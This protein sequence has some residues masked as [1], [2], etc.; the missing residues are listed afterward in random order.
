MATIN[1]TS[2]ND[3]L[4]GTSGNDVIDGGLGN[5][6]L[7]GGG[8]DDTVRGGGGDDAIDDF[9]GSG[10]IDG[11]DGLD[12]LFIY[13]EGGSS[14]LVANGGND[15]D[16]IYVGIQDSSRITVNGGAGSDFVFISSQLGTLQVSLGASRD[17][18]SFYGSVFNLDGDRLIR[19]SGTTVTDF[20][21]GASG[22]LVDWDGFLAENLVGWDQ[23]ANPFS[24]GHLRLVSSGRDT[25]VQMDVD[26]SGGAH[27]Y[28]T[29]L[30]LKSVS[31]TSLVAENF[32]G[33]IPTGA[34]TPGRTIQGT[35][36]FDQLNS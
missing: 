15:N 14:T 2:G 22:D 36:G 9:E 25:L 33:Y 27:G 31:R 3:E 35:D 32:D 28:G 5:D 13:R 18:L 7:N 19:W 4:S 23:S 17:V 30:I 8:G 21:A 26:G 6:N 11:G 16:N 29:L 24:S 34:Q 1:G 20:A 10:S 12:T